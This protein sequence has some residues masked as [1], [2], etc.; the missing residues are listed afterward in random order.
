MIA[1]PM[2]DR[3]RSRVIAHRAIAGGRPEN[4]MSGI[5]AA[6]LAGADAVEIDARV[7]RDGVAVVCHDATPIRRASSPIPVRWM[8][9]RRFSRLRDR[10]S[11]EH[12]PTLADAIETAVAHGMG[13]VVDLKTTG[14]YE[15]TVASLPREYD[16][17]IDLWV[18]S[19]DL[20][21]RARRDVPAA[22]IGWLDD[23]A[24]VNEV[25]EYATV[26][27]DI[28]ADL[29][30]VPFSMLSRSLLEM[31][32]QRGLQVVCWVTDPAHTDAA[33]DAQPDGIVT[34]WVEE[35]IAALRRPS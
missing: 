16:P 31:S 26:A 4:L 8:S 12:L 24:H 2:I 35:T 33:V 7:T 30:S 32:R 20:V 19:R 11:G 6:A 1:E 13:I 22:V 29:I 34:D 5:A 28:G 25:Q 17:G 27:V 9:S 23:L 10:E 3:R 18:R 14:A 21:A 15:A